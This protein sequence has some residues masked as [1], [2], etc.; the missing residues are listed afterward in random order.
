MSRCLG[1]LTSILLGLSVAMAAYGADAACGAHECASVNSDSD[2]LA[3]Y[4]RAFG[5]PVKAGDDLGAGGERTTEARRDFGL[6]ESD[7]RVRDPE[8]ARASRPDSIEAT[9]SAVRPEMRGR[10]VVTLDNGQV[11]MQSESITHARLSAGDAVTI[12][13]AALG[14]YLLVIPGRVAMRVRRVQ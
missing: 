4:D 12:R 9:V 5:G 10:F 1:T 14:S 7:K 3:C 11:W 8:A 13:K 2:R 6:S